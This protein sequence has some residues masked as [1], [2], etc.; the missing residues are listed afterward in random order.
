M[1]LVCLDLEGVLVPEI[2]LRLAEATGIEQ[3]K[4]TTRDEPDYLR[5]MYGRLEIL[6][7]HHLKIQ[8]IQRI[9]I[10]MDPL[11]GALDFLEE[12]RSE[13]QVVILSDTFNQFA[14]PI[15]EGL[16]KPTLFCNDLIID[17][18]G[19][20]Q[21]VVLRQTDG[22]RIAVQAFQSMN[23]PVLACGDSYNDISMIQQADRGCFFR[24]P[25]H[26]RREHTELPTFFEYNDLLEF[27]L[28]TAI[29]KGAEQ[30]V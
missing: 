6:R 11:D 28:S 24:P 25:D 8:D 7:E 27:I 19:N 26:I 5:L 12:L 22:K 13:R 2:W 30:H 1:Q 20:I 21:D 9:I 18:G 10:N 4:K 29:T 3:L 16:R 15:M 14:R 17:S 23:L